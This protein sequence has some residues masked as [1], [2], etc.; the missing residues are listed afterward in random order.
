MLVKTGQGYARY[1]PEPRIKI[2]SAYQ[3]PKHTIHNDFTW[4]Q[5]VMLGEGTWVH[6]SVWR[7][8]IKLIGG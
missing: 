5:D 6:G 4:V 3:Q 2:G 8:L 1:V 7:Y